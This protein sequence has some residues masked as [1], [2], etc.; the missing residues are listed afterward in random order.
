[1]TGAEFSPL[2]AIWPYRHCMRD[3]SPCGSCHTK[4]EHT[5]LSGISVTLPPVPLL[6]PLFSALIRLGRPFRLQLLQLRKFALSV[7]LRPSVCRRAQ[8]AQVASDVAPYFNFMVDKCF[9]SA[10]L[11]AFRCVMC[12]NLFS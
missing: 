3:R 8:A 12:V 7:R 4:G 11:D 5:W 2:A 9:V 1:M 6:P 10:E